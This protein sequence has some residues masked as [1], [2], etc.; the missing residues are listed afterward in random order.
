VLAIVAAIVV[1]VVA[2]GVAT[3]VGKKNKGAPVRTQTT[4]LLQ[5]R[6]PDGS[7]ID[8][9]LLA[10]DPSTSRGVMLFVPSRVIADIP[11]QGERPFGSALIVGPPSLSQATVADLVGVT[12]DGDIVFTEAAFAQ[13]IDRLGGILVDVKRQV[14]VRLPN[15]TRR[16]I[17]APGAEQHLSG[18]AAVAYATYLPGGPAGELL[19]LAQLEDVLNGVLAKATTAQI[20]AV[21]LQGVRIGVQTT[22]PVPAVAD[23]LF[24]L[25][26]DAP[27]D[28]VDYHSLDVKLVDTGGPPSFTL[29]R[30]K[31][32]AFVRQS[33]AA[34]IPKGLLSGGNT[35]RIENGVGTPQLGL[36]TRARLFKAGFVYLDGGNVPGFPFRNAPSAVIVKSASQAD[37]DRGYAV[38]RALG[39]PASDVHLPRFAQTVAD[40]IVALGR[41]YRP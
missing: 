7:A 13:F 16:V 31:V 41:D 20:V 30:P 17:V 40:V 35:V 29:D 26:K 12:V 8:T 25:A 36:T 32:L 19:R 18:A 1:A 22:M 21:A 10:H 24:G 9:A 5:V 2:V 4:L 3:H 39:L 14:T 27:N 38:A 28:A 6:G 37:I 33:L 34:S 11:G 15:G 23:L